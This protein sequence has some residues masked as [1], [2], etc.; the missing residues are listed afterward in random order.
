M[1]ARQNASRPIAPHPSALDVALKRHSPRHN[2]PRTPWPSLLIHGA[3]LLMWALLLWAA[4]HQQ[5][6]L[7]WSV[8]VTYASYDTALLL[9]VAWQTRHIGSRPD[10]AKPAEPAHAQHAASLG[11]IVAA[12]NEAAVL[13]PTLLK[14]LT[15]SARPEQVIVA[16]DGSSDDTALI[17]S[18]DFGLQRPALGE[19]SPPSAEHPGLH[20][21]RLSHGGKARA[22]NAALTRMTV[23]TVI[24]VD[25]DTQLEPGALNAVRRAFAQEPQLVAATGVLAPVCSAGPVGRVMQAFQTYEYIRNFLSRRAWM[26]LDSLLLIS[27]AFAAFRRE[28]VMQVGGFDP[29][30]LVEDYE[31]I[32]RLH[33]HADLHGLDWTVR[34]LGQAQA[35]TDAPSSMSAFLQQRRRWFGGFLQTQYWYRDMVGNARH[36]HLGTRMLPVKAADTLQPLYGLTAFA[37]LIGFMACG[38]WS[39]VGAALTVIGLKT[40]IDLVYHL[41]SLRQYRRWTGDTRHGSFA[42]ALLAALAEPFTFQ[43]LRHTAAT[44]GWWSALTGRTGRGHWGTQ[45]R[46]RAD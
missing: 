31:L 34:V 44:W 24:T 9:F 17:L 18:R 22:L 42:G 6:V 26:Q 7:A 29:D 20:W 39:L 14:L 37:T 38:Q 21:L 16:D 2:A 33:R 36:G 3:V 19:L 43:L 40:G 27:G 1:S 4:F 11:V 28:P 10:D 46:Q 25:A 32:H 41:W 12:H 23:D 5:G 13:S 15:A 35:R 45:A 8:G 30:C